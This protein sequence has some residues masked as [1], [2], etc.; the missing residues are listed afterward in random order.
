MLENLTIRNPTPYELGR[1]WIIE[2]SFTMY[3][4]LLHMKHII[5]S[6]QL[7]LIS[8]SVISPQYRVFKTLEADPVFSKDLCTPTLEKQRELTFRRTRHVLSYN[9]LTDDDLFENPLRFKAFN[10]SLGMYD[11]TV[12][13]KI[14]LHSEV[15][16]FHLLSNFRQSFFKY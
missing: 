13:V 2:H 6:I 8:F 5:M 14:N 9:F 1:C 11:W 12:A 3:V 16:S 4:N 10:E 15:S 7:Y